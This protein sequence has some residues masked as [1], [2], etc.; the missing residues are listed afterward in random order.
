MKDGK[1]TEYWTCFG[2]ECGVDFDVLDRWNTNRQLDYER[3]VRE[4]SLEELCP[5]ERF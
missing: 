4:R 2:D 3:W 1:P 5:Q